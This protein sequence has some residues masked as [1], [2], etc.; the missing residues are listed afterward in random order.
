MKIGI[1]VSHTSP[2]RFNKNRKLGRVHLKKGEN[3]EP[4]LLSGMTIDI[5]QLRSAE[6][7]WRD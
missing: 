2:R 1:R 3:G 4:D 7:A 5:T 6:K